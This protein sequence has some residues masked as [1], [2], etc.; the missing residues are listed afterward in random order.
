MP[1]FA[2]LQGLLR[3]FHFCDVGDHSHDLEKISFGVAHRGRAQVAPHDGAVLLQEPFFAPELIDLAP[4]YPAKRGARVVQV[5]GV[6]NI[7]VAQGFQLLV[8]VSGQV[9]ERRV[10]VC[11]FALQVGRRDGRGGIRQQAAQ[12]RFAVPKRALGAG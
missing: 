9:L 5:V 8:T 6:A 1:G 4:S 10:P 3:L 7:R 12:V 11:Q 2:P